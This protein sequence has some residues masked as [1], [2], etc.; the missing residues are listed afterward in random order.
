M[1]AANKV[2][3]TAVERLSEAAELVKKKTKYG[4]RFSLF[5]IENRRPQRENKV[6]G[7]SSFFNVS[8]SNLM[9]MINTFGYFYTS[10]LIKIPIYLNKN[11]I[12]Q[13]QA[14][15]GFILDFKIR[16]EFLSV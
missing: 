2:V 15:V 3:T 8:P 6:F 11:N 9:L 1:E 5:L 12:S 4:M 7:L 10:V 16:A 13:K 14:R